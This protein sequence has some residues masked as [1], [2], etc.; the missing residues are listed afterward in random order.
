MLES[1]ITALLIRKPKNR[2][3]RFKHEDHKIRP[4]KHILTIIML[5]PLISLSYLFNKVS[6]CIWKV[7]MKE[8]HKKTAHSSVITVICGEKTL[9]ALP[10]L[11]SGLA[12]HSYC[13]QSGP[14][15]VHRNCIY[16]C[17]AIIALHCDFMNNSGGAG[18]LAAAQ[19][20]KIPSSQ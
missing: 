17:Q 6:S 19:S 2:T 12:S 7:Y 3:S 16:Y 1:C 15:C 4:Y 20:Q 8:S 10:S 11:H 18:N 5:C 13:K 14:T 9:C